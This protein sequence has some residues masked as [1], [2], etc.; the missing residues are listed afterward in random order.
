VAQHCSRSAKANGVL[1]LVAPGSVRWE[2]SGESLPSGGGGNSHSRGIKE[3]DHA[4]HGRQVKEMGW[5]RVR[6]VKSK[7]S[8]ETRLRIFPTTQ[9][10]KINKNK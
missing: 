9:N 1:Q 2:A 3:K 4:G 6:L 7:K 8:F 10:G 5:L